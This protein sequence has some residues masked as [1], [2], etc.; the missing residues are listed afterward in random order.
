MTSTPFWLDDPKA[1]NKGILGPHTLPGI[2]TADPDDIARQLDRKKPQGKSGGP[3]EDKGYKPIKTKITIVYWT[4]AQHEMWLRILPLINPR[5]ENASKDPMEFRHPAV[6]EFDVGPWIV[7][8]I[9]PSM[10][11]AKGGRKIEITLEEWFPETKTA[12]KGTGKVVPAT[13]QG[14][15]M[16][17]ELVGMSMYGTA[18]GPTDPTEPDSLQ[19]AIGDL[20]GTSRQ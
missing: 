15:S 10:P 20:T 1:W 19:S 17:G 6:D 13:T 11:T 8:S 18:E 4:K 14:R 9:K 3:L 12:K 2:V 16:A 5:R 7:A